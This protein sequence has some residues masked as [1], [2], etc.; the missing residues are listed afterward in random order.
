MNLRVF[1]KSGVEGKSASRVGIKE[2]SG[3]REVSK[4]GFG[5]G[6]TNDE[7]VEASHDMPGVSSGHT[8]SAFV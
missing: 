5:G 3:R 4:F 2:A 6:K 8:G 7:V 1:L